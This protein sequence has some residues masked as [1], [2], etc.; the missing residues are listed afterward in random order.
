MTPRPSSRV[1][2]SS[3]E[4]PAARDRAYQP[5]EQQD[6]QARL[7]KEKNFFKTREAVHALPDIFHYWSNK[8]I[9]PKLAAVGFQGWKELFSD[10]LLNQ[11]EWRAGDATRFLSI[12][13]GNCD[14]EP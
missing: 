11:C 8:Y 3:D 5:G 13:C 7:A 9:R 10:S 12:G 14:L 1:S 6:Y 4:N 2:N